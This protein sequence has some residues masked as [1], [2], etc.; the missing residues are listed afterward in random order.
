MGIPI[1][2]LFTNKNPAGFPAGRCGHPDRDFKRSEASIRLAKE[3]VND[4]LTEV[5]R[6]SVAHLVAS[7]KDCDNL[8]YR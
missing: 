7:H 8:N 2:R 3:K 6:T 5:I 4:Y 1:V